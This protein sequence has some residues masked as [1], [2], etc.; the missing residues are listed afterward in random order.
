M[1]NRKDDSREAGHEKPALT[2]DEAEALAKQA[3]EAAS[4]AAAP[5]GGQWLLDYMNTYH[6]VISE[7][8][9]E[10]IYD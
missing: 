5:G 6:R 9:Y 1:E 8:G 2:Y 4:K 7:H 3:A 10:V